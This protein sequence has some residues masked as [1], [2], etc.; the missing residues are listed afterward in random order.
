MR[1]L[2]SSD[3]ALLRTAGPRDGRRALR[4]WRSS[5]QNKKNCGSKN[6]YKTRALSF[7]EFAI[8]PK[9]SALN[10]WKSRASTGPKARGY[11]RAGLCPA[12]SSGALR[13]WEAAAAWGRALPRASAAARRV[14]GGGAPGA[15]GPAAARPG[16]PGPVL[17]PAPNGSAF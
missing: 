4:A 16:T 7:A 9:A 15:A 11:A 6:S 3:A 10:M 2:G 14:G 12:A 13:R 1:A 17:C 5:E 8:K